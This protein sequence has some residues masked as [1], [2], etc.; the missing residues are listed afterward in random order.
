[1]A[2][3]VSA[4]KRVRQNARRAARNR[5]L[6]TRVTRAVRTARE[7]IDDGDSDAAEFVREAQ[8]ALDRAA[9]RNVIHRNAAAR[10]KSRL[11]RALKQS[12]ASA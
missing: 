9:R 8:S 7:A 5:P 3:S 1:M 10:R 4:R 2:H 11:V 6:R 12:Q